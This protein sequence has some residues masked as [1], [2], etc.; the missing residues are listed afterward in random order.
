MAGAPVYHMFDLLG[1]YNLTERMRLRFGVENMFNIKPDLTG[2]YYSS[3]S[4]M[5][6]GSFNY[7]QDTNGRR[8][9]L[10]ARWEL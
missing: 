1:N 5:T 9:Y 8:F 7:N 2:Y 10:G 6:G 3:P 4:G